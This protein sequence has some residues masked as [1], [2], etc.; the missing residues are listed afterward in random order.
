[1]V[2]APEWCER[3]NNLISRAVGGR[4]FVRRASQRVAQKVR[5]AERN[6][7]ARALECCAATPIPSRDNRPCYTPS[8]LTP[9]LQ[10]S[11]L[12]R[13]EKKRISMMELPQ[14]FNVASYLVDRN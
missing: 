12:R 10:D 9:K 5:E 2:H 4:F 3:W 8:A 6:G 7:D 14:E 11:K 13:P 1:M